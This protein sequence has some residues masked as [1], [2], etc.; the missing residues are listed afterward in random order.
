MHTAV[1]S[2]D[3]TIGWMNN[4]KAKVSSYFVV[5]QDGRI[6]QVVD[7]GDKAWT[8]AAGNTAWIGVENEGNS[9]TAL[10]T[11][12]V[13]ANGRILAWLHETYGVPLELTTDPI[14]GHG[15][16]YHQMGGKAWSPAG[17]QCPGPII[18]AQL[19]A[20][21][22]AA[23]VYAG[24]PK[25]PEAKVSDQFSPPLKIVSWTEFKHPT[26]GTCF[27]GVD[28]TGAVFCEPSA[29]Y[30]GGA[31]GKPYFHGR[32]AA[33]ITAVTGGYQITDS[34]GEKYGPKF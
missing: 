24:T 11:A 16:G 31:N 8:Q 5:A 12:Q 14:N 3:G 22:A 26:L 10:T 25:P 7:L 6:A 4:P 29:A 13:R 30:M 20:I 9:T 19:P 23:R 17:H 15:L 34:A 1:G 18:V 2:F 28:A 21:V 33:R 27:A 32:H